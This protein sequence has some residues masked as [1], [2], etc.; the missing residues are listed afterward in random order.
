M[1]QMGRWIGEAETEG[2]LGWRRYPSVTVAPLA[3]FILSAAAKPQAEGRRFL[4]IWLRKMERIKDF[5]SSA[6]A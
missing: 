2:F 1:L 3:Q 4:P 6:F 5:H